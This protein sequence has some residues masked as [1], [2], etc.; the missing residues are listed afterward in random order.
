MPAWFYVRVVG[1]FV[2][3]MK[4]FS[5]TIRIRKVKVTADGKN[6]MGLRRKNICIINRKNGVRHKNLDSDRL[7]VRAVG[8]PNPLAPISPSLISGISFSPIIPSDVF[9]FCGDLLWVG[10]FA[11]SEETAATV[12]SH[13][14]TFF[15]QLSF[16]VSRCV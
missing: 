7:G 4:R 3:H 15:S 10:V 5:L 14:E 13:G 8:D 9:I 12:C 11:Q 2:T 6:I 16:S 1:R